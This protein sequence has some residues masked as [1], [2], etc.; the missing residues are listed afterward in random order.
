VRRTA[1]AAVRPVRPDRDGIELVCSG[2]R[3]VRPERSAKRAVEG[4]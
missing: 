3:F 4:R 1:M 2:Q